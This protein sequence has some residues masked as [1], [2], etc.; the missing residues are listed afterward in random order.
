[1]VILMQNWRR[2]VPVLLAATDTRISRA[3]CAGYDLSFAS[4]MIAAPKTSR[5]Q[6]LKTWNSSVMS[7]GQL[8]DGQSRADAGSVI[9]GVLTVLDLPDLASRP[10]TER[11]LL[12]C[13]ARNLQ[14]SRSMEHRR[15]WQ[16][17]FPEKSRSRFRPRTNR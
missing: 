7:Y 1:M 15:A 10:P 5:E 3:V 13:G 4:Q 17:I 6:L 11:P 14:H 2:R 8:D 12:V 16:K 9:P